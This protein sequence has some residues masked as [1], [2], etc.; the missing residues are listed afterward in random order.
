M[1]IMAKY[2]KRVAL[3]KISTTLEKTTLWYE[4]D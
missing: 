3:S 1:S 4:I 2:E